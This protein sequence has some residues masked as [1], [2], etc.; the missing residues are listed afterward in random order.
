M[1]N[2]KAYV[3]KKQNTLMEL[4]VILAPGVYICFNFKLNEHSRS[5]CTAVIVLGGVGVELSHQGL[6]L[7]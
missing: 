7:D 4:Y 6:I 3:L 5:Q 2:E 1:I